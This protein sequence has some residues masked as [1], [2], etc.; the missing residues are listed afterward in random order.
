MLMPRVA[1]WTYLAKEIKRYLKVMNQT[2]LTPV[3]NTSLYLLI[4]GV[5]MGENIQLSSG[6]SYLAFLIPGLVMMACLNNAFQNS[7]SSLISGKFSGDLED[8]KIVPIHSLEI[9]WALCIGGLTRGLMVSSV[10]FLVGQTF[11]YLTAGSFI[12]LHQ[13]L[14][15][16]YF[17]IIGGLSFALLGISVAFWAQNFDQLSAVGAFVLTPLIFLGGVFY[18][19]ENLAPFWQ[20]ITVINPLLYLINGVRYGIIGVSDVPLSMAFLV[21]FLGFVFFFSIAYVSLKK[22]SYKRW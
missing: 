6:V 21:S 8:L 18:S 20:K 19:I 12:P 22:S 17:L 16:I 14:L 4:F 15:L 7:S 5:S 11:H 1:F 2:V 9:L 3:V 13:P 10:T